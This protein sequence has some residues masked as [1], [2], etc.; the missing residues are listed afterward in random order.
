[1][2]KNRKDLYLQ[3]SPVKNSRTRRKYL[4]NGVEILVRGTVQGVGFRPFIFNLA[5]RLSITGTVTNTGDGVAIKACGRDEDLYTFLDLISL[6][7]PP[8]SRVTGLLYRHLEEPFS[9]ELFTIIASQASSSARTAIPPD[10]AVCSDCLKE[11]SDPDDFRFNYP[12]I[13]CTNCGPR[14]TITESIPYDRP[15]TSMKVFPMCDRCGAEYKDP[16]N[17]RFHAQPNACAD[18]GPAVSWHDRHGAE[19]R[20]GDVLAAAVSALSENAVVAVRGLG[21]FHLCVSGCSEIAVTRLRTRKQRPEKPLAIMIRDLDRCQGFLPPF[22]R[23]GRAAELP[24]TP[25]RSA[26]KKRRYRTR[27][28]SRSG[29]QRFGGNASLHTAPPSSFQTP[30]LPCSTGHDERE[31]ERGANLHVK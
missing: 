15:K 11:L 20:C 23:G 7:P 10:I 14:F 16:G 19:I 29:P 1:M 4:Y 2:C 12:F 31:Y 28:K 27:S 6:Q 25:D 13:N 26:E 22:R 18:C 9:A 8:L 30:S 24:R 17:R 21:G 3:Y 5:K